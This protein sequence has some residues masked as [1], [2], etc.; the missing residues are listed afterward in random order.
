MT[1]VKSRGLGKG[2]GS[3]LPDNF[4]ESLLIDEKDRV[5]KLFISDIVPD[6]NQP[7]KHF[8]QQALSELSAS[9]K[10][11]GV[12]QPL[13]VSP[14]GDKYTI[15][16]GERRYRSA[17]IAGLKQLPAIVRTSEELERTEIGLVE[18]VQRV[19]LSPI[20]Q[21]VSIVKLHEQFN[22]PYAGIAERLGKA[23]TTVINTARLLQLPE[24]ARKALEKSDISEGHAR[25]ILALKSQTDKQAELLAKITKQGWSVRQ[26][27][28]FV[29]ANKGKANQNLARLPSRTVQRHEKLSKKLGAQTTIIRSGKGGRLQIKFKDDDQL[30]NVLDKLL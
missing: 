3:L 27:E 22:I 5:Q 21:A 11:H 25:A 20:E 28:Q 12:L 13:V 26:A 19:D 4:D 17:K 2:F 6:E 24:D 29:S 7:R 14:S 9:I 1:K 23:E 16:A 30:D 15:I 18:N 8:D 10:R